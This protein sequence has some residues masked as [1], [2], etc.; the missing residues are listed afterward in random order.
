MRQ[1]RRVAPCSPSRASSPAARAR[2]GRDV[3]GRPARGGLPADTS[4]CG[5][6]RRRVVPPS[7]RPKSR[8][9]RSRRC[10]S[11][12][13][14][15]TSGS[16]RGRPPS[17]T[18]ALTDLD[19]VLLG[20][21]AGVREML[22]DDGAVTPLPLARGA[23]RA[24]TAAR[25]PAEGSAARRW[26]RTTGGVS[27]ERPATPTAAR[28]RRPRAR[29]LTRAVGRRRAHRAGPMDA[30]RSRP[31]ALPQRMAVEASPETASLRDHRPRRGCR[32]PAPSTSRASAEPWA[33]RAR[34]VAGER[35]RRCP[36]AAR[37]PPSASE[38]L[39]APPRRRRRG[40]VRSASGA[41]GVNVN[42]G[43]HGWHP[44]RRHLAGDQWKTAVRRRLR[45]RQ[46]V[47]APDAPATAVAPSG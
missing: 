22:A 7:A 13:R 35:S 1:M 28:R 6:G 21:A 29:G 46:W 10:A 31:A 47:A 20:R 2:A 17:T 15:P 11:R 40:C 37:C 30:S 32:R 8:R 9:P 16:R 14:A 24:R 33:R 36:T 44:R 12:G 38:G 5:A 42:D 19:D 23:R 39:R 27:P 41:I 45:S 34:A 3:G 25:R 18:A 43:L 4:A 26:W